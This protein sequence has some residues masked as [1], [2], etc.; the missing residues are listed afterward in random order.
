M[1]SE[2]WKD[3]L[4]KHLVELTERLPTVIDDV[5]RRM[6]SHVSQ[7]EYSKIK[8][9][10]DPAE[11]I[12]TFVNAINSRTRQDFDAFC[13]ALVAVKQNDLA[14]TLSESQNILI[15]CLFIC[16]MFPRTSFKHQ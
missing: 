8:S 9:I 7:N 2:T 3:A 6:K 16:A 14:K 4:D 15:N 11:R 1:E 5:M 13:E 10:S 12:E